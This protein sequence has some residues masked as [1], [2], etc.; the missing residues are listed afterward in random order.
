MITQTMF[1]LAVR[2]LEISS[3]YYRDVLGFEI[4]EIGDPGWRMYVRDNCRIMSGE[5]PD[6]TNPVELGDHSY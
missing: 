2:S 4:R 1:V 6:A 3:T 5:C